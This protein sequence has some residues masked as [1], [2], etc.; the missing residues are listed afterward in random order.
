MIVKHLLDVCFWEE[1]RTFIIAQKECV[2]SHVGEHR[3]D[4]ILVPGTI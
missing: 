3:S 2:E 1:L 4:G